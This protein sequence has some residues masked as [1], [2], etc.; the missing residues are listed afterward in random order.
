MSD[1][2]AYLHT[3]RWTSLGLSLLEAMTLGAPVLVLA[4]TAAPEAVP[5][6]AGVVSSDVAELAT[7]ARRLAHDHELAAAM[8]AAGRAHAVTNFGLDRFLGD[9]DR[10]LKGVA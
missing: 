9:W 4:T 2:L 6:S 5:P 8:G 3:Y 1:H 7:A 10:L